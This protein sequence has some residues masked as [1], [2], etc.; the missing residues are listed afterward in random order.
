MTSSAQNRAIKTYRRR[1]A[2]KGLVRFEIVAREDDR[3]LI[4]RLARTLA[5]ETS[6]A[7]TLRDSVAQALDG[8]DGPTGGI[9][10]ALRRSPL[11]SADIDLARPRLAGREVEL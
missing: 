6:E 8:G 3:D 11:V 7:R 10:A 5:E 1:L 2:D 4:R 9:L